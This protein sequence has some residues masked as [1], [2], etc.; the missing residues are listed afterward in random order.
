[1]A[2]SSWEEA[3]RACV[4]WCPG[5]VCLWGVCFSVEILLGVLL[6]ERSYC[7]FRG[8]SWLFCILN[9]WENMVEYSVDFE[10]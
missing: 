2:E 1:V 7:G 10:V 8:S 3:L 9:E 4:V 6:D 5:W